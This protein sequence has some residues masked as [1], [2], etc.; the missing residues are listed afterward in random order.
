MRWSVYYEEKLGSDSYFYRDD[1]WSESRV[2][3]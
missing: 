1:R 3:T 2:Q